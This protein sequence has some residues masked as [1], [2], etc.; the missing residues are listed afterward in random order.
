MLDLGELIPSDSVLG[1]GIPGVRAHNQYPL[2]YAR[3]A[4]QD[5]LAAR[6]DGDFTLLVARCAGAQRQSAQWN[7]DAVMRW[8]GGW[9][10]S[11][12]PAALSFGLSASC[13]HTGVAG[14]VRLT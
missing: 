5:A 13:W 2:L 11:Q 4:W 3:A 12:I 9:L 8:E 6:P 7:G 1:E 10:R 14:Y